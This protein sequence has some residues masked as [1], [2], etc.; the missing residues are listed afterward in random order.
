MLVTAIPTLFLY[1]GMEDWCP[2]TA[3][4]VISPI[5]IDFNVSIHINFYFNDKWDTLE[6]VCFMYP[7]YGTTKCGQN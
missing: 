5:L 3:H 4:K 1:D 6:Y 2:I 7:T